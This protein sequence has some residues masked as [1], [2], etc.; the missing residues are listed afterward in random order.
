LA[1]EPLLDVAALLMADERDRSA[2]DLAETG[3]E[4]P[5]VRAAAVAVQLHPVVDEALHVVERVRPLG[6]TRELDRPPDRLVG[7]VLLK[8][9]EL[10]LE[11]L[12]L[13]VDARTAKQRQPRQPRQ[14]L[15]QVHLLV[16]LA[17]FPLRRRPSRHL[18]SLM[19]SVKPT[20]IEKVSRRARGTRAVA[21]GGRSRR[22]AR[23][24]GS[25]LRARSRRAASRASSA[26]RLAVR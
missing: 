11:A 22:C 5:V 6:V 24:A 3:D 13:T 7:R 12:R 14:A 9:L 25:A 15:A 8:A 26:A 4:R 2:V 1:V 18:R 17:H 16:T 19:S 23:S 20:L 21:S 10:F